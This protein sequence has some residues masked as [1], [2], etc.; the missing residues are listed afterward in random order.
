MHSPL[1]LVV[2]VLA[3]SVLSVAVCRRLRLPSLLGYLLVGMLLG[4]QAIKLI[5]DSTQA[6]EIAEYGVVFLMFSIGL[7]FSLPQ[8][9]AMR[10]MVLGL[11]TAQ[12]VGSLALFALVALALSQTVAAAI[13][14]GAALA[15]S[16]TAIGIKLLAE[17]NELAAPV[18]KPVIGVLLFQDL[19]VVPLLIL[20]P[21]LGVGGGMGAM[22][23]GWVV[24]KMVVLLGLLLGFG[25][26]VL[27]A[28]LGAVARHKTGELFMLNVLLVTLLLAWL[29]HLAGLPHA[30]GA[31]VAGML[32][33]ETEFK[34]QVEDDIRPF[35]DVLLGMF[36]IS[37]GMQLDGA[38]VITQLPWVVL[39]VTLMIAGKALILQPLTRRF[40]L[41]TTDANIATALLTPAGEFGFVLITLGLTSGALPAQAA[42]IAIA[43]ML[44]SMLAAPFLPRLAERANQRLMAND[45]LARSADIFRIASESMERQDHVIICGFGRSGQ[46]LARLL[47]T[48]DVR[49]VA[50]DHDPDRVREAM[51]GLGADLSPASSH[52]VFGD[53][54]RREALVAAGAERARALVVSFAD[55]E[56]ALKIIGTARQIRAD[57][58]IVVRTTDDEPIERLLAAGA[59][60]VVPEVLEGSLMLASHSLLLLGTPLSRVLKRIRAVR[61]ERY[62]MFQGFYRGASDGND[63]EGDARVLHTLHLPAAASAVGRTWGDMAATYRGD[64]VE[65]TQVRRGRERLPRPTDD[66][67]FEAGDAVVLLGT[68]T[69]VAALELHL[70]G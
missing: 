29:C 16:S 6:K 40:G 17:R 30:L 39:T 49:F 58:P 64:D 67:V 45:F 27:R 1:A 62:S 15:M 68:Q 9:R 3:A 37:V 18:A 21:A 56:A 14:L 25:Q 19:A 48:E 69:S 35:R 22:E 66:F 63:S 5:P 59:T 42:Q 10:R 23:M 2:I 54:R 47:E 26:P 31:F 28:W 38:F 70:I 52:V 60:E 44:I 50:L 12:Y 7:E 24:T 34:L 51:G 20:L 32:I 36:F 8:F 43:A 61:V 65:I 13:V 4:P 11:G 57:L 41:K 55:Q 33:A 53:A 46:Y